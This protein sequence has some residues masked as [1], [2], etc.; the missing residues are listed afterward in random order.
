MSPAHRGLVPPALTTSTIVLILCATG[1][2]AL[3]VV[4]LDKGLTLDP[5]LYRYLTTILSV[6]TIC[7][8]IVQLFARLV[9]AIRLADDAYAAGYTDGLDARPVAHTSPVMRLVPTRR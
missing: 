6:A 5:E 7:S 4:A 9:R 2:G 1:W 8:V 3:G